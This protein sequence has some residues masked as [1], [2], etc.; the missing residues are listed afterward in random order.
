VCDEP[1]Q[2]ALR[3]RRHGGARGSPRVA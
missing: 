1:E 2:V 3:M